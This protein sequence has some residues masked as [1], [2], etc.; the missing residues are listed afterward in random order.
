[1]N[2]EDSFRSAL[3]LPLR[4][5]PLAHQRSEM[6]RGILG[7]VTPPMGLARPRAK[8]RFGNLPTDESTGISNYLIPEE[9][10]SRRQNGA[11]RAVGTIAGPLSDR[12]RTCCL[13]SRALSAQARALRRTI[14][15]ILALTCSTTFPPPAPKRGGTTPCSLLSVIFGRPTVAAFTTYGRRRY[16]PSGAHR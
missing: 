8:K 10:K 13:Q 5:D 16:K 7:F 14:R 15:R 4:T 9:S 2:R 11:L 1:M 12:K 3:C 6:P